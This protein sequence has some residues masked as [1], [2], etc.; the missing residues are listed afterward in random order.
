MQVSLVG[1]SAGAHLAMMAL[2]DRARAARSA[3]N[4][5]ARRTTD[6]RLPSQ[7]V[8]MSISL[9]LPPS[10]MSLITL[11]ILQLM[12]STSKGFKHY[13]IAGLDSDETFTP[14][15]SSHWDASASCRL[16]NEIMLV[17]RLVIDIAASLMQHRG[18]LCCLD[19]GN[20]LD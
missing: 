16:H 7:L 13:D 18:Y 4:G 10:L 17:C 3:R 8:G 12:L 15:G 6:A 19:D 11:C 2:L 20:G 1:H 5:K 14:S 9:L